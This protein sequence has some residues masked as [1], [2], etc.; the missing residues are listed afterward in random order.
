MQIAV[1]FKNDD[2][3]ERAQQSYVCRCQQGFHQVI[4]E[5]KK[6]SQGEYGQ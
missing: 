5:I 1:G 6:L 4:S 3:G 2:P